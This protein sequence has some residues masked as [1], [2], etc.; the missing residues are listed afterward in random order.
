MD[1][2]D[3]QELSV[4]RLLQN[5]RWLFPQKATLVARN[6]FGDLFVQD[7]SGV[8]WW[9]QAGPG[10]V[11]QVAASLSDFRSLAA[12]A[13]KDEWFATEDEQAA[14]QNGLMPGKDQCIAFSIPIVFKEGGRPYVADLYEQVSFLGDLHRQIK[15]LPDGAKVRLKTGP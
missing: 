1:Y 12:G 15:D 13:Q 8:I 3:V 7:E 9:L 2:F 4:D 5:W 11:D 6:S 14:A 10:T